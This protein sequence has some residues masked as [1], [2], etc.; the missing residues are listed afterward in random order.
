MGL[1]EDMTWGVQV[2]H[3]GGDLEGYH[4]DWFAIPGAQVGAVI[5]TNAENGPALRRPFMRRLLEVLYDGRPEAAGDVT[6]AAQRIKAQRLE[7]RSRLRRPVP[8]ADARQLAARYVS[9]DLGPLTISRKAGAVSFRSRAW[10]AAVA[11]RH[12]D[13]ST[14]SFITIDPGF[15][16]L[17]F[18]AGHAGAKR[19]LTTRDG[20]HTYVFTEAA[21]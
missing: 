3:H 9:P 14:T 21:A 12:N 4:S 8:A 2:I 13:D 5:L 1:E 15:N 19:T 10:S 6:A 20:Q 18:V 11:S 17:D 16:G 7:F